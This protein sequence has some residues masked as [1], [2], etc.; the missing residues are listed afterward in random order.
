VLIDPGDP[1]GPSLDRAIEL[2]VARGGSIVAIALTHADPD[3]AAGSEAL[4]EMLG[5]PV[6]GGPGAGDRLPYDVRTLADRWVLEACDVPITAVHAPGPSPDHLAF[7]VGDPGPGTVVICGDLDGG[8]GARA[9]FGPPDSA[10]TARSI[11]LLHEL[12]PGADW[13][14]GHPALPD[15]A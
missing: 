4:A 15:R 9:I 10:A 1:T 13:L 12:A 8:R 2:A 11:A 6:L 3:H 7:F 5:V 14:P